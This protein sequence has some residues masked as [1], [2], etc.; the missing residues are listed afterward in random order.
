MWFSCCCFSSS[1]MC[2]DNN[3]ASWKCEGNETR[4]NEMNKT[5]REEIIWEWNIYCLEEQKKREGGNSCIVEFTFFLAVMS[6]RCGSD[7]EKFMKINSS[8]RLNLSPSPFV[9]R[10]RR[11][12]LMKIHRM[13]FQ[14]Q[15]R[16]YW[17]FTMR[18]TMMRGRKMIKWRHH[19][20]LDATPYVYVKQTLFVGR[21]RECLRSF[22]FP[23]I[24]RRFSAREIK[25]INS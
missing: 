7:F 24:H 21:V 5:P 10:E 4:K 18:N 20:K 25:N 17:V 15:Q 6:A 3:W 22:M 9:F 16:R 1:T 12:F 19:F 2:A 8:R 23:S 13:F 14:C 11:Q